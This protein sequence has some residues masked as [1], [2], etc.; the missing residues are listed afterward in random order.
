MF[1]VSQLGI[2]RT[3]CQ[4][5]D[6]RSFSQLVN[7]IHNLFQ[8]LANGTGTVLRFE[9]TET[10]V[11]GSMAGAKIHHFEEGGFSQQRTGTVHDEEPNG[12][13]WG[14]V[15]DE[16]WCTGRD[17][18]EDEYSVIILPR[19]VGAP[20]AAG[21][22]PNGGNNDSVLQQLF[23][24]LLIAGGDFY[25]PFDIWGLFGTLTSELTFEGSATFSVTGSAQT[26]TVWDALLNSGQSLAASA[27]AHVSWNVVTKRFEVDAAECQ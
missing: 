11:P 17:G 4:R 13:W 26:L 16:G 22:G 27:E 18:E 3:A 8:Q 2:N 1:D 25:P 23:N 19:T 20:P 14:G 5:N 12:F 9:L 6:A 7:A 21:G 10:L 24:E 15:G